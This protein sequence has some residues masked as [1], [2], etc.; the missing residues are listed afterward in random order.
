MTQNGRQKWKEHVQSS[1]I[2]KF[3]VYG[4]IEQVFIGAWP[5]KKITKIC[6]EKSCRWAI[7]S[8]LLQIFPKIH[9]AILVA[10]NLAT[11]I[12]LTCS[13]HFWHLFC[14]TTVVDDCQGH[15]NMSCKEPIAEF[16]FHMQPQSKVTL[17]MSL[18]SWWG[19]KNPFQG[20]PNPF[21]Q[22]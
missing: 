9:S 3:E 17:F 5:F 20:L 18:E 13:F 14:T 7:L 4:I 8:Q 11:F 22:F 2:A 15:M 21:S 1:N 6:T 12:F 16:A 10:S 19:S